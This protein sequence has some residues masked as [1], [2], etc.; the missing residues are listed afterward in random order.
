MNLFAPIVQGTMFVLAWTGDSRA[1]AA[2]IGQQPV[3]ACV[4]SIASR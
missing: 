4:F 1:I 2:T 3:L